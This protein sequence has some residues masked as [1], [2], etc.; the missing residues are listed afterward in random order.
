MGPELFGA[1]ANWA[2]GIC[3]C[4]KSGPGKLGPGK[5]GP[6][7]L[8]PSRLDTP[9]QSASKTLMQFKILHA[10]LTNHDYFSVLHLDATLVRYFFWGI[11][12]RGPPG[13][14]KKE[15]MF[16][17]EYI[18]DMMWAPINGGWGKVCHLNL[19]IGIGHILPTIGGYMSIGGV[20]APF[21]RRVGKCAFSRISRMYSHICTYIRG[22]QYPRICILGSMCLKH[23]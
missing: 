22:Y 14:V 21:G 4:A 5:L 3:W 19:C 23:Q 1:V 11:Y 9:G 17:M 13:C 18:L 2:P 20:R 6:G 16:A 7:R 15:K 8:G 12:K 10:D